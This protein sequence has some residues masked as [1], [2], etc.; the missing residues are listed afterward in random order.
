MNWSLK[1]H[2]T[3]A[4]CTTSTLESRNDGWAAIQSCLVTGW[5][6][7]RPSAW[8][9]R[10]TDAGQMR[11]IEPNS[12]GWDGRMNGLVIP[13]NDGGYV[14]MGEHSGTRALKDTYLSNHVGGHTGT[15]KERVCHF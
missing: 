10:L 15:S 3:P 8:S 7:E 12:P 4:N 6:F 14:R 9:V 2:D 5:L 11:V 13:L 1:K